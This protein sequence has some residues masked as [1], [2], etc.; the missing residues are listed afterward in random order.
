MCGNNCFSL[1]IG[2]LKR[3]CFPVALIFRLGG[4]ISTGRVVE[5]AYPT[6]IAIV[7]SNGHALDS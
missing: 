7:M 5:D 1:S 4:R 6:Q 2:S 3:L